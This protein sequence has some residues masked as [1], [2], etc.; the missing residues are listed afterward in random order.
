M[1]KNGL[2]KITW[3]ADLFGSENKKKLIMRQGPNA[4]NFQFLPMKIYFFVFLKT[5]YRGLL[6]CT[7]RPSNQKID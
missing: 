7:K 4:F 5:F 2:F 1:R 3:K 6:T